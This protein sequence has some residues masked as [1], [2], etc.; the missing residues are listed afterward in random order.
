[1]GKGSS[2]GATPPPA[3]PAGSTAP[4]SS[5]RRPDVRHQRA[6][7]RLGRFRA[8]RGDTT[9]PPWLDRNDIDPAWIEAYR[10]G[11]ADAAA[12]APEPEAEPD[13]EAAEPTSS[14]LPRA[15]RASGRTGA[16]SGLAGSAARSASRAFPLPIASDAG[17]FLLGILGYALL[18]NFLQGGPEQVRGWLASKFL[19]RPYGQVPEGS[20]KPASAPRTLPGAP[21]SVP[22]AG[23]PVGTRSGGSWLVQR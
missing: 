16:G 20:E 19:N 13:P 6:A 11:Q 12:A 9:P 22:A 7:Y 14:T 8:E 15:R 18:Y 23:A 1:V 5:P 3:A 2:T 4:P 21:S 10:Q 17:G